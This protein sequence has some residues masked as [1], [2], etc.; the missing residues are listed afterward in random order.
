MDKWNEIW[1]EWM[2]EMLQKWEGKLGILYFK[3]LVLHLKQYS[4]I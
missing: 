4:V 2:T 3:V 1:N